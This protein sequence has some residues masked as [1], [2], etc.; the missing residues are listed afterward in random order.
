MSICAHRPEPVSFFTGC[1]DGERTSCP[2]G[3]EVKAE[4]AVAEAQEQAS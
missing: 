3:D 4:L 2:C 1:I